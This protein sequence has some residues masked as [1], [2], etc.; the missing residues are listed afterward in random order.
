MAIGA[1][2]AKCAGVTI[3]SHPADITIVTRGARPADIANTP[4]VSAVSIHART[5]IALVAV[6]ARP[7]IY[8]LGARGA[9]KVL[10]ANIP[11]VSDDSIHARTLITHFTTVTSP[12]RIANA[13][14]ISAFSIDTFEWAGVCVDRASRVV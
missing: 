9:C 12:A 5:W 7:A 14:I 6:F 13:P 11:K 2:P 1:G 4:S 10:I 3:F 8:T